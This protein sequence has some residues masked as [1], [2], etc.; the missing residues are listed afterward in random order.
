VVDV[1]AELERARKSYGQRRWIEA[2]TALAGLDVVSP[3]GVED[4]ERLAEALDLVGRADEAIVV[5]QRVYAAR[6]DAGD[7]GAAL[8]DAFWLYRALAFNAKFAHAGAWIARA[9]RLTE[10]R[11]GCAERGYLMLPDAER[12]LRDGDFP[13]AYA[14]AAQA[15]ALGS[16]CGDRDLITVAAH[17]QGRAL[18]SQGRIDDGLARLDEAMLDISAGGT[19]PRITAWIYCKTI[20]TCQQVYDV[21]RAREWTAALNAWCDALPQLTGAYSGMCRIHRSELLQLSGEWSEAVQEARLERVP[22][23]LISGC[24]RPSGCSIDTI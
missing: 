18:V 19:S 3:L 9:A 20:Q 2:A 6:V 15:M 24:G 1:G 13:A 14:T 12:Q 22:R 16:R 10:G 11:G 21:R 17:L 7:V 8:R 4:L 5:L 23:I